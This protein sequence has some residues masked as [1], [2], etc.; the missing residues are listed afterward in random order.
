[1][2][3]LFG[4]QS[5]QAYS[6]FGWFAQLYRDAGFSAGTA[7]LLLGAIT[8][9]SIPLSLVIPAIAGRLG[10]PTRLFVALM[11]CY[12]VG[13]VG[14]LVAP[15]GGAWAW[16]V[17]VG[18]GLS[19]FPLVLTLIGMRA[20]TAA[21]TAALSGFTQSV[22]YTISVVGP[23]AIG[24]LYDATNGWHVPLFLLIGVCVPQLVAGLYAARPRYVEDE[25]EA[26]T[27]GDW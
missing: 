5:L 2:A 13:Y 8:G 6:V 24:A 16:A 20:R 10:D 15:H 27:S 11:A 14:L 1:M 7:G 23:F 3:L 26:R 25:L 22:G 18:T 12:P 19:T 4:L 17:L 21:G 9:I